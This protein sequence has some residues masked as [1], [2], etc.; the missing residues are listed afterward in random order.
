MRI[1]DGV[2]CDGV[3]LLLIQL[4]HQGISGSTQQRLHSCCG[5][6]CCLQLTMLLHLQLML[7][8]EFLSFLLVFFGGSSIELLGILSLQLCTSL[9]HSYIHNLLCCCEAL[10][11]D[12]LFEV[13]KQFV[14]PGAQDNLVINIR[15]VDLIEDVIP[16]V[17][18]HNPSQ[19]V[20]G[21]VCSRMAHMCNIIHSR[22]ARVPSDLLAFQREKLLLLAC[23]TIECFQPDVHAVCRLNPPRMA[24]ALKDQV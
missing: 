20:K 10:A 23:E 4:R 14:L 7:L 15:D 18:R 9:G 13:S 16:K 12:L 21:Q 11:G 3:R 2:V 8:Q 17:I 19:D 6:N 22:A 24:I 1:E 5:C